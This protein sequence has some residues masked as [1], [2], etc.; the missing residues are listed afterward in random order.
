[1]FNPTPRL[2]LHS[3]STLL[4][5]ASP[6]SGTAGTSSS[7]RTKNKSNTKDLLVRSSADDKISNELSVVL[8]T[9]KEENTEGGPELS[10][11]ERSVPLRRPHARDERGTDT[12]ATKKSHGILQLPPGVL[13]QRPQKFEAADAPSESL[14]SDLEVNSGGPKSTEVISQP[15]SWTCEAAQKYSLQICANPA[16]FPKI[17][18]TIVFTAFA[19]CDDISRRVDAS[20]NG[21]RSAGSPI[22]ALRTDLSLLSDINRKH[23]DFCEA[24]ICSYLRMYNMAKHRMITELQARLHLSSICHWL[25]FLKERQWLIGAILHTPSDHST[26]MAT[27]SAQI[28]EEW[29]WFSTL[30]HPSRAG[31]FRSLARHKILR[32]G[33]LLPA[34]SSELFA[35]SN[36]MKR[37]Q[38]TAVLPPDEENANDCRGIRMASMCL[39]KPFSEEGEYGF[40][41]LDLL[42]DLYG[43]DYHLNAPSKQRRNK[44][45]ED[46][47]LGPGLTSLSQ[48]LANL[49][50]IAG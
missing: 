32:G 13:V 39:T 26:L 35:A 12:K 5:S 41:E 15:D 44:R 1:M 30:V 11:F 7:L 38:R 24:L 6:G 50:L 25:G 40:T 48:I 23:C 21:N 42:E 47:R 33:L 43:I 31:A 14:I 29:Y 2:F 49:I 4:N 3:I 28:A 9:A 17:F 22:Q 45:K 18:A 20:L 27:S 37:A 16:D 8:P 34:S 46:I 36:G 19:E 10:S